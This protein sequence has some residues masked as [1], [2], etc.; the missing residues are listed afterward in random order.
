MPNRRCVII[1]LTISLLVVFSMNHLFAAENPDD[2]KVKVRD[3]ELPEIV[4]KSK[5][6]TLLTDQRA[7]LSPVISPTTYKEEPAVEMEGGLKKVSFDERKS[8]PAQTEPGCMYSNFCA[9]LFSKTFKGAQGYYKAAVAKY[10]KKD[11]NAAYELYSTVVKKYPE[12][13]Y[14]GDAYY[15]VAEMNYKYY[16]RLGEAGKFYDVVIQYYPQSKFID[17]AYYSVAYLQFQEGGY[18]KAK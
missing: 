6:I 2:P 4:I 16:D 12:S 18:T 7:V 1:F 9:S 17:Y 15:W 14:A 5:D 11:Y 13:D 10:Y 3:L 8:A